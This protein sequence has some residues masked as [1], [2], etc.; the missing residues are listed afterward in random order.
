M[1]SSYS[2]SFR[3]VEATCHRSA[4]KMEGSTMVSLLEIS[5]GSEKK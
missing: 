5:Q 3:E 4:A 1:A 2:G